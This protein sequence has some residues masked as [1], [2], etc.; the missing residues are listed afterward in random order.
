MNDPVLPPLTRDT[1]ADQVYQV[2]IRYILRTG[3]EVGSRLPSERRFSE[4]LEVSRTV[5]RDALDRLV[6][7]GYVEKRVGAGVI[8]VQ[9][10]QSFEFD[11]GLELDDVHATL[12]DLYRARIALEVGAVEWVV[13][14]LTAQDIERL[15]VIVDEME[16]RIHAGQSILKEDREFHS[17]LIRACSN[18]VII[19]FASIIDAYFDRMRV[20]RPDIAIDGSRIDN[21]DVRHRMIVMA[22]HTR[23][24]EA[25]RQALRLHFLPLPQAV[26]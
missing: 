2:M 18:K 24:V 14:G 13:Q 16:E 5:V 21:M 7:E 20:Y 26:R 23:D 3:A 8:L 12:D 19:Q 25:V 9:R 10:P 22:L 1:L 17:T 4:M 6:V 11:G 15:S